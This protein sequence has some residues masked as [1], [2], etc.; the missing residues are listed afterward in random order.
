MF[1]FQ[2]T[3]KMKI[4][5]YGWSNKRNAFRTKSGLRCKKGSTTYMKRQKKCISMTDGALKETPLG[6]RCAKGHRRYHK[7]HCGFEFLMKKQT[8]K[9]HNQ[10]MNK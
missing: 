3:I 9:A 5:N 2:N 8:L 4:K 7:K 1:Y 6:K 10:A